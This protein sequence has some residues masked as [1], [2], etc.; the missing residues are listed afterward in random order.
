MEK[1]F[2]IYPRTIIIV[3]STEIPAIRFVGGLYEKNTFQIYS[4]KPLFKK[5]ECSLT[6]YNNIIVYEQWIVN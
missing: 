1:P 4:N 6:T 5:P 2:L 3:I